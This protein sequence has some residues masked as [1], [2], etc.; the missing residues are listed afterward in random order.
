MRTAPSTPLSSPG[1]TG[2]SIAQHVDVVR[3][4]HGVPAFAGNDIGGVSRRGVLSAA[5]GIA[6]AAAASPVAAA[7]LGLPVGL[8]LYTV[9]AEL[10]RDFEGTLR[11]IAA[12]GYRDVEFAGFY[13]RAP[14]ALRKALAD[15]G[16]RSRS[17]HF[18]ID[19]LEKSLDREIA[20]AGELGLF[21]MIV[22]MPRVT[23]PITLDTWK[24]H[25]DFFNKAGERTRKAG[26]QF[27]FH[28]HNLEFRSYAGV[29]ALDE[30]IRLTDPTLVKFQLD[31]GWAASAGASPVRYLE[32]YPGRFTSLHVKDIPKSLVPNTDM[33]IETTAVGEGSIDWAPIFRAAGKAGITGYYVEVEPRGTSTLDAVKV[34]CDYLR[35]L[36]I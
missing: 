26:L 22:A 31:C 3:M 23:D 28:N 34:S 6:F 16:L 10:G 20:F 15:A 12:L 24:W 11:A 2:R 21:D 17:A 7:P 9:G 8:Q 33:R 36:E 27:G 25:A 35:K 14:G 1:L 32:T 13:D 19:Q 5:L 29:T 30:M 18:G 4:S